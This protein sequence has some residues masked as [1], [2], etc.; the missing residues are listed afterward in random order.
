M[1]QKFWQ[2]TSLAG[3]LNQLDTS[4]GQAVTHVAKRHGLVGRWE[5]SKYF[6]NCKQKTNKH[7][8]DP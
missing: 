1:T 4:S 6:N 5:K 8:I 3:N 7:G 2:F